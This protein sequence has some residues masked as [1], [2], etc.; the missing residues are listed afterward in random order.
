MTI[1]SDNKR[2]KK[3]YYVLAGTFATVLLAVE[4]VITHGHMVTS[5]TV[6]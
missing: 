4:L 1:N 2:L 6:G 3:I 5:Y